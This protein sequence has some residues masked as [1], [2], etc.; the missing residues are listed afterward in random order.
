MVAKG[1]ENRFFAQVFQSV[2][3]EVNKELEVL[4]EF[5]KQAEQVLKPGGRLVVLSYHSLED[6]MV[7]KFIR[8]GFNVT[9][10][11]LGIDVKW[12][13]KALNRKP[14]LADVKETESNPRA[15]SAKLR[16]AE[17]INNG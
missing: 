9:K 8:N 3:I 12:T 10:D 11:I 16:I 4:E 14:L 7:K 15:R 5:L 13:L 2:R 6:R 1:K 17:K